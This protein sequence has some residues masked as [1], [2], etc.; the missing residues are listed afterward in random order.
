MLLCIPPRQ[1]TR[2]IQLGHSPAL[3]SGEEHKL[4]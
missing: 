2:A 4:L 1:R 3:L